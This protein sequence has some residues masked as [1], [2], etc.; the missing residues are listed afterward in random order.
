VP[1]LCLGEPCNLHPSGLYRKLALIRIYAYTY[2]FTAASRFQILS[3]TIV[4]DVYSI[5]A[6]MFNSGLGNTKYHNSKL[7][8]CIHDATDSSYTPK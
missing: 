1:K 5:F 7:T 2:T 3:A 6:R 4:F 8:S